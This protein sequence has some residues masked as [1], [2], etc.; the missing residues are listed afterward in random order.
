MD[1]VLP[2]CIVLSVVAL[3]LAVLL[4][5]RDRRGRAVQW[6]GLAAL[7]VGLYLSGLLRLVIDFGQ[8]AWRWV[9]QVALNP[10]TITGL[11]LIGLTV[12]LWVVGGWLAHRRATRRAVEKSSGTAPA[13]R[14]AAPTAVG[15]K[16]SGAPTPKGG[17]KK[18]AAD[19][20]MDEIEALLK[21][22]GIE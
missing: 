7:P 4:C 2:V 14:S 1:P 19:P 20:E 6:L 3:V 13:G 15:R 11:G 21:Q 16:A 12:V 22:R 17:S 18:G 10:L 9:Q 5:V 8:A